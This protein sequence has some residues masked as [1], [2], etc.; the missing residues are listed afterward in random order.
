MPGF[1][2]G[3]AIK[4]SVMNSRFREEIYSDINEPINE[5]GNIPQNLTLMTLADF[6]DRNL[7]F[8]NA[9][10]GML[11]KYE[12]RL[13]SNHTISPSFGLTYKPGPEFNLSYDLFTPMRKIQNGQLINSI[14]F[15][16][17]NKLKIPDVF[18]IGMAAEIRFWNK[19]KNKKTEKLL[20]AI[21]ALQI[22]YSQLI[23]QSYY[24][25]KK[26][27]FFINDVKEIHAGIQ[28][29]T[30]R[31]H[32]N[33]EFAI[34]F[35]YY[36]IPSHQIGL[37]NKEFTALQYKFPPG[38][39]EHHF[40]MGFGLIKYNIFQFASAYNFS[41]NTEEWLFS[42]MLYIGPQTGGIIK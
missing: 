37:A 11:W 25:L 41:D 7:A 20:L 34:R 9:N 29:K 19:K 10:W 36:K 33:Y 23:D 3:C 39:D 6:S 18:G 35:G 40:T 4:Y 30:K 32:Q 27:A 1:S 16:R 38:K 5:K 8:K 24:Q 13:P 31:I 12:F 2:I 21:D 14:S 28:F 15:R 22:R 42:L 17:I 26:T